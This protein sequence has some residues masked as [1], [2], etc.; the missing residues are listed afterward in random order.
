LKYPSENGY[1]SLNIEDL[2]LIDYQSAWE[3]QTLIHQ[4]LIE[5][6]RV[7]PH[8]F[9]KI[10]KLILCEHPHVYTL[11]KSG[12]EEHLVMPLEELGSIQAS[13]Y[14]INR[15]GD[16]TYHGP[17]QLV[18]Y[19]ILDLDKLFTDVHKYVRLLE[20]TVIQVLHYY[21]IDGQRI[22]GLTGVWLDS[23]SK[24]ARK[25]CAIGVH[26]SRWVSLHGL[27][28]NINSDLKYFNHIIPCG[29]ASDD[30]AVTSLQVELGKS[31]DMSEV[32]ELFIDAF[33]NNFELNKVSKINET[34]K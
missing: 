14:K 29:I 15:G 3:Y 30:K 6:K 18:A 1:N 26:L 25:I 4:G 17:G 7:N 21:M 31:I 9:D 32:K 28:F 2:G 20:E 19:P 24:K 27:A 5:Q 8:S 23:N 10:H 16:I 33:V 22:D 12:K 11:G 13:F 34:I